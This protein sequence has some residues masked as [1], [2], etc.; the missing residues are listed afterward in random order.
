M[1]ARIWHPP[2]WR[3]IEGKKTKKQKTGDRKPT[4]GREVWGSESVD[5]S[6]KSPGNGSFFRG[7]RVAGGGRSDC[8]VNPDWCGRFSDG[9]GGAGGQG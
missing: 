8:D 5:S 3:K 6:P 2:S 4:R 9:S 7:Q 1:E